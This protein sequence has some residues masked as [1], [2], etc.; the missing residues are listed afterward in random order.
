MKS[1]C[2]APDVITEP[3]TVSVPALCVAEPVDP[4]APM[5]RPC[6]P[7]GSAADATTPEI[8]TLSNTPVASAEV[9]WLLT[10]SPTSTLD[11]SE[12]VSEPTMVQLVPV[13]DMYAVMRLPARVS[14]THRGAVPVPPA[15][16]VVSPP[17]AVRR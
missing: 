5:S 6:H 1:V 15:V 13:L 14:R 2:A 16:C 7:D 12:N 11:D 9:V 10:A 4:T 8:D 3:R 17:P